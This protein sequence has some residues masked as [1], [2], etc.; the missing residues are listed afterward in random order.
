MCTYDAAF[1]KF[2]TGDDLVSKIENITGDHKRYVKEVKRAR[3]YMKNRWMEDN[4]EYYSELYNHP[5]ADKKRKILNLKN[6]IS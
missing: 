1:H 4:I 5:Y 3:D 2:D 6:N